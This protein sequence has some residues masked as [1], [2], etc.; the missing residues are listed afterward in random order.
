MHEQ[1]PIQSLK[2]SPTEA[3]DQLAVIERARTLQ[4]RLLAR[5][6][7]VLLPSSADELHELRDERSASL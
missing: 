6:G 7:G 1:E 3:A 2:M 4:E 5:R